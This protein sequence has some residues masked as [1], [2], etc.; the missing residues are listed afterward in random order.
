MRVKIRVFGE[1]IKY[2]PSKKDE[3]WMDINSGS[4]VR[5]IIDKLNM[6]DDEVWFVTVGGLHVKDDHILQAEDEIMIFDP[7]LGG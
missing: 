4:T 2:A 6:P 7:V 1:L 5:E 3:F